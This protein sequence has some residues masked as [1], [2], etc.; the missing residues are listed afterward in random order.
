MI[1]V[2]DAEEVEVDDT[3]EQPVVVVV[4]VEEVVVV[5]VVEVEEVVVDNDA[6]S[7]LTCGASVTKEVYL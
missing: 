3:E 5:M 4:E 1:S 7:M 2:V 6:F